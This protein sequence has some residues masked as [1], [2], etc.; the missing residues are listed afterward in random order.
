M[1]LAFDLLPNIFKVAK[2][3]SITTHRCG[4]TTH[5]RVHC[6]LS[7]DNCRPIPLLYAKEHGTRV[8]AHESLLST[9]LKAHSFAPPVPFARASTLLYHVTMAFARHPW[10]RLPSTF[11]IVHS[12][13][14]SVVWGSAFDYQSGASLARKI[15]GRYQITTW[16]NSRAL[17]VFPRPHSIRLCNSRR[18]HTCIGDE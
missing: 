7:R 8:D 15:R 14:P 13:D 12:S 9:P 18:I 4:A 16:S 6:N 10:I 5:M 2:S 17:D 11:L 1:L 3:F